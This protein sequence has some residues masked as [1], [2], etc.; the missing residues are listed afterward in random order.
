[1]RNIPR[2]LLNNLGAIILAL[3]LAFVIW[4]MSTLGRD[5]FEDK[6]LSGIPVVLIGQPRDVVILR[7]LPETMPIEVRVRQSVVDSIQDSDFQA[8]L[9]L[10]QVAIDE[11]LAENGVTVT[12]P[13]SITSNLDDVRITPPTPGQQAVYL[14]SLQTMTMMVEPDLR[15]TVAE[16][17]DIQGPIVEPVQV[18][19]SGPEP[20]LN[21][22]ASVSAQV[23]L[24]AS[25][26]DIVRTVKVLVLG[27]DGTSVTGLRETVLDADGKWVPAL[28]VTP[29]EV[30]VRVD[31]RSLADY[32]HDIR[33][34]ADV[35]GVPGTGYVKGDVT[36]DPLTVKFKG[37]SEL[38]DTL[39]NFVE[40]EP[41]PITGTTKTQL[42]PA[43][44]IVPEGVDVVDADYQTVSF[45][46]V[47]VEIEPVLATRELTGTVEILRVPTEWMATAVPSIVDVT[48]EGPEVIVKDL[49]PEDLRIIVNVSGKGLGVYAFEPQVNV[50]VSPDLVS[51]VSFSPETILVRL[52]AIPPPTPTLTATP[53]LTPGLVVPPTSTITP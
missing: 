43:L 41:V 4:V 38:L 52:E 21:Q 39:P 53:T 47:T 25:D 23:D 31:V 51:V 14:A 40:T 34:I 2:R 11:D 7:A 3:L 9:D 33:V 22:V 17:Y 46:V 27:A 30:S 45:V 48:V 6:Q 37:P 26:Q 44:L 12:V 10:G 50:L 28:Q 19:I 24:R 13:I 20:Y 29:Q 32:R 8:I 16:G 5:P 15:G 1:M 35:V 36:V 42:W 18:Q 49:G